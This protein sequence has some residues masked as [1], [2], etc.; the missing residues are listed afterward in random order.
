MFLRIMSTKQDSVA[1]RTYNMAEHTY[2]KNGWQVFGITQR[3]SY[4]FVG[5]ADAG[6]LDEY[7]E[8]N[9]PLLPVGALFGTGTSSTL[10]FMELFPNRAY[11][12]L[13]PPAD[14]ESRCD[15]AL[16]FAHR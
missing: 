12:L 3:S 5:M 14:G 10:E 7:E 13:E 1:E 4:S 8:G 16:R 11:F 2:N 6:S 15:S 9:H